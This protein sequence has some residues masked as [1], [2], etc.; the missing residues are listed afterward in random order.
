MSTKDFQTKSPIRI[1]LSYFK[2][3]KTLFITQ[4]VEILV[5]L[6]VGQSDGIG[7]HLLYQLQIFL[8]LFPGDGPAHV[9]PILV[10]A[11]TTQ[12]RRL[13]V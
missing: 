2:N 1:F 8:M 3:H 11:N 9:L 4:V 7:A 10:A 12:G 6:I 5:M 13:P